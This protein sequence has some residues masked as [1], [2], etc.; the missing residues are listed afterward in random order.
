MDPVV[1]GNFQ[2]RCPLCD[3]VFTTVMD[4]PVLPRH[5]YNAAG[6]VIVRPADQ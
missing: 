3:F 4:H 2:A 1:L 6:D 5:W